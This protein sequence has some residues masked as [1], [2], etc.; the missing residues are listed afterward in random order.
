MRQLTGKEARDIS[1]EIEAKILIV[2]QKAQVMIIDIIESDNDSRIRHYHRMIIKA[3]IREAR[4][5]TMACLQIATNPRK[6]V[7]FSN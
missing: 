5:W 1:Q 4:P 7:K 3:I 6:H 2:V